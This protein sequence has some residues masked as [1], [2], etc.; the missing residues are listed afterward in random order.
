[1]ENAK[2]GPPPPSFPI[3][4]YGV[5]FGSFSLCH[6]MGKVVGGDPGFAS[7]DGSEILGAVLIHQMVHTAS[8]HSGL[9]VMV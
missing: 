5:E 2:P 8:E 7:S 4:N 3:E 9:V 6:T 1:M